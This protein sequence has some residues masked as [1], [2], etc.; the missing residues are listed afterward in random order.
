MNATDPT[1]G[2]WRSANVQQ[3]ATPQSLAARLGRRSFLI[4]TI[5]SAPALA[6]IVSPALPPGAG[7]S[8]TVTSEGAQSP[9]HSGGGASPLLQ[10][11]YAESG[12]L[13]GSTVGG[14]AEGRCSATKTQEIE[15]C[16]EQ[17]YEGSWHTSETCATVGPSYV[18]FLRAQTRRS[19]TCTHGRKF[20][21]W[22]WYDTPG[23]TPEITT[24][25]YPTASGE[26][27]C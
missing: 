13:G 6:G 17:L 23:G 2:V 4:A 7:G 1:P 5:S 16:V 18:Q 10:T 22:N 25:F 21:V 19:L 20:R 11:C 27:R 26:T 24:G 8:A 12:F 14:F 9:V 15:V 3:R